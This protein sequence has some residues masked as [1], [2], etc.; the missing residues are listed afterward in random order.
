V[1]LTGGAKGLFA[2]FIE[3]AYR[4]GGDDYFSLSVDVL[5]LDDG[6]R[7]SALEVGAALMIL[8]RE[9]NNFDPTTAEI[10]ALLPSDRG[11]PAGS[12]PGH[13]CHTF[14]QK[15]LATLSPP[16]VDDHGNVKRPGLG[17]IDRTRRGGRR[18]IA[19]VKGLKPSVRGKKEDPPAA[20]L[21]T[22]PP[23]KRGDQ[24]TTTTGNASSSSLASL[25]G[26][27]R[28]LP[29]ELVDAV[30]LVPDL[31]RERLTGWVAIGGLE[32]ARRVVAWLRIWLCHPRAED[33]PREA[34]WAEKALVGWRRKLELGFITLAD[35]DQQIAVKVKKWG[36]KPVTTRAEPK[37]DPAVKAREE[38]KERRIREAWGLMPEPEK[39]AIRAAVRAEQ[40]GIVRFEGSRPIVFESACLAELAERLEAAEP[41]AP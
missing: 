36:P 34:I 30:G 18:L 4:P 38:A 14:V 17:L 5:K 2:K 28:E 1:S 25:P 10:A 12:P 31:S 41:R 7:A 22:P 6:L 26:T 37:E 24:E 15:G 21:C 27:G 19:W 20:P 29:E 39:E 3:Y 33:R 16:V 13:R 11:Q 23:E 35:I 32:L 8:A 40:P 9:Q